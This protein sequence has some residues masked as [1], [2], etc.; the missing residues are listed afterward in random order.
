MEKIILEQ[1]DIYKGNLILVNKDYPIQRLSKEKHLQLVQAMEGYPE[2]L[3]EKTAGAML[4]KIIQ[5]MD[6]DKSIVPVSGFRPFM[7]QEQIYKDSLRE[8]GRTF[9]NKYVA[10]PGHSE[11][12][13]GY[14][15]DLARAEEH[16]DFI[17]PTFTYKGVCGRFREIAEDY[18][19][20]ERYKEGKEHITG[21]A[22]EPWHFRYVGYPH[23]KIMNMENLSLEEYIEELKN[24]PYDGRHLIYEYKGKMIEIYYVNVMKAVYE[25]IDL[26]EEYPYLISGNNVDGVIITVWRG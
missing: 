22:H 2:I 18:G 10:L 14:A 25:E 6:Q 24:Y 1:K 19:Y 16:I 7:E 4:Q 17:R 20:V 12:Q 26:R 9:T 8:N 13:T 5:N 3:L 23:A 21:I 15:I 11:H